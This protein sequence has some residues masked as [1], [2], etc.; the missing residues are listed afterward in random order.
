M[1]LDY[2]VDHLL[3]SLAQ[4]R[5][6]LQRLTRYVL[7][8]LL[9]P[10][11][12][13]LAQMAHGW[14]GLV[15][16]G[17]GAGVLLAQIELFLRPL[18]SRLHVLRHDM[19]FYLGAGTAGKSPEP[20]LS[21]KLLV[22][23]AAALV[24][25]MALFLPPILAGAPIWQRLLALALGAGV[26]WSIWQRLSQII[27]LLD[28]IEAHLS[29][30]RSQLSVA[31]HGER[32]TTDHG[33]RTTDQAGLLDPAISHVVAGLPLPVLP[34]SPAARALLRVEAYLLLRDFPGT[35]DRALLDALAGLAH[36]AH[37]DELRHWLL[38][39]VG[40]KLYLPIA[41]NG[42]LA[43]LLGA[44]AR[45]LGMDG[46]YSA[47]LGTWLVR[48]PPARSY[49]VA[50]RLIDAL[51]ALRLPPQDAVLPHHLTIQ[52]DLGS[53]S[54][55]LSIVHLAATP[56]L[57]A[58][59]S[60]PA[61]GDE[62]PFI[63][64]GGGVLDDLGGRGRHAGPRTDFVD[65]F[66]FAETPALSGVEHRAAH[67]INLRIKQVLAFG[68]QASIRP[69]ERRSPTERTAAMANTRLRDGVRT[70]LAP[71]GLESALELDWLGGRWSDIWPLIR[72][73]SD[74]KERDAQFLEAA[75]RL[76]DTALDEIESIA[77]GAT[78]T[79]S[80]P[81]VEYRR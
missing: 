25:S 14:L 71:Y 52:G 10:I 67:T 8:L 19:Q 68:V 44:T 23:S 20:A 77:V 32:P 55:L 80:K 16:G 73:M 69:F 42:A 15:A 57:F 11:G 2:L 3:E 22:P 41:A 24:V 1:R 35:S 75:Q 51:V 60:G 28:R 36:E 63:M 58:E 45:R 81:S 66:V 18:L 40:G 26:L 31:D 5:A 59:R 17:V 53:Q 62:R 50:G 6:L 64:R 37:Q 29:V 79:A 4:E 61:Q 54:K 43:R 7:P 47:S 38:P 78:R 48:L 30:V 27:A 76:R 13:G 74:L 39:P 56:L 46:G 65:G 12:F 70:F 9:L 34:L 21:L 49:A 33:P 72:R